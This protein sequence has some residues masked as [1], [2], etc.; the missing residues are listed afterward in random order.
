MARKHSVGKRNT[1]VI[2][3]LLDLITYVPRAHD[4]SLW[5]SI[6]VSRDDFSDLPE[7]TKVPDWA[8]PDYLNNFQVAK[9][10]I[11][12][13]SC[14]T[15]ACVAGWTALLS[16]AKPILTNDA[17]ER[18]L[19]DTENE[20]QISTVLT[21][22]NK[23]VD[24]EDY[25]QKVLGITSDEALHLF[26]ESRQRP[27]LIQLLTD[28]ANGKKILDSSGELKSKYYAMDSAAYGVLDRIAESVHL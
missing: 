13:L 18:N 25:A 7:D 8:D 20:I 11:P 12:G 3:K 2:L 21:K 16:G 28:L 27:T 15:T 22:D 19:R 10:F 23:F 6:K 14:G 9:D 1:E 24:I 17:V 26:S 4:Q 5:A